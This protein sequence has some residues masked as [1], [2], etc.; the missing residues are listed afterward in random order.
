MSG[1]GR[2]AL[3]KPYTFVVLGLLVLIVGALA[4]LRM[5]VD[6]F[7]SIDIPIIG[8]AWPTLMEIVVDNRD[9]QMMPGDYASIHLQVA[10]IGNVLSVPASALIFNARGLWVATVGADSRVVLKQVTIARDLGPTVELSAGLSADDRVVENPPDGVNTGD[11]V[12][13]VSPV[14]GATASGRSTS[15]DEKG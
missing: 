3:R 6:I 14:V 8:V 7:P 12:H 15:G 2:I 4:A 10:P 1:Y 9:A 13:V 5:P 11:E